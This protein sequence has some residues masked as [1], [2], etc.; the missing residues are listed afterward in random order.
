MAKSAKTKQPKLPIPKNDAEVN[1][2][3]DALASARRKAEQIRLKTEEQRQKLLT[4][5]V[6]AIEP[7]EQEIIDH[8]EALFTY[9]EKHRDELTDHGRRQSHA[10][11]NG[12]LGQRY[13]PPKTKLTDEDKILAYLVKHRLV[14]FYEEK[15]VIRRD[16]LLAN[17]ERASSIP[18]VAF[19]RDRIIYV[20]P[21]EFDVEIELKKKVEPDQ[22]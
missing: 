7:L 16:A 17:R 14:E 1:H 11:A 12:V 9:F 2:Y 19:I 13:T 10:F 8:A 4:Y 21:D 6:T 3:I 22:S 5:L 18:G 15:R 20:Q